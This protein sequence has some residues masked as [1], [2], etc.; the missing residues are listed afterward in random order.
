LRSSFAQDTFANCPPL[1]IVLMGAHVQLEDY[2]PSKA[3]LDFIRKSYD[4]CSAFITVCGG[5]LAPFQ[6][7]LFKDKTVTAPQFLLEQLRQTAPE[8]NWVEKRWHRDGKLWTSGALLNGLDLMGA[9]GTEYWGG[10]GTLLQFAL[11]SGH[12][13]QRDVGYADAPLKV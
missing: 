1:D 6:A 9:F 4:G 3:E 2:T 5:F 8:V 13:P 7:G 11:D 10:E 12:Y